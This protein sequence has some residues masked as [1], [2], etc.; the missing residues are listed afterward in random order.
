MKKILLV[1]ISIM[2][3]A[4]CF[5]AC[6][7][8]ESTSESKQPAIAF[9]NAEITIHV[10]DS[11]QPEIEVAKANAYIIWSTLDDSIAKVTSKGVLTG[12]LEG[13]TI[14]YAQ[15]AG[16]TVSCVVK[17]LPKQVDPVLSINLPYEN[18]SVI[19]YAEDTLDLNLAVKLG[20]EILQGVELTYEVA[21]S[22]IASVEDGVLT[23][24][25]EGVT[26]ITVSATH[27]GQT[28]IVE[29]VVEVVVKN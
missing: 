9:V 4:F 29:I 1:I 7:E 27:E 5:S 22:D 6:N 19:V 11:V 8:P 23:A 12:V 15:F 25:K 13:Q 10:G 3:C 20:D 14:C 26:T 16:E 28:A 17:V 24:L 2:M 21:S 18:G